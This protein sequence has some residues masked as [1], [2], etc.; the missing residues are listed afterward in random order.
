MR[1]YLKSADLTI[2]NFENPAPNQPRFHAGGTVFSADPKHIKALRDAGI[3]WVSIANNH[4]GDAG[5]QGIVQT[6]ANLKKNGIKAAGAGK[7]ITAARAPRSSMSGT[8]RS[9]CSATTPSPATTRRTVTRRAAC[10]CRSRFD[11]VEGDG[12]LPIGPVSGR[13]RLVI[14]RILRLAPHVTDER[15]RR[16]MLAARRIAKVD[17]GAKRM[18]RDDAS[19]K[20]G[21]DASD[22][23]RRG[24]EARHADSD[25]KTGSPSNRNGRVAP[26]NRCNGQKI[27]QRISAAQQHGSN[28]SYRFRRSMR[29]PASP[30]GFQN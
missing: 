29:S 27:N 22:E 14:E 20:I 12:A 26:V 1:D 3:D 10:R 30:G 17:L 13:R 8:S 7:D 18:V 19:E 16:L 28:L 24:A 4:I 11:P 9:P 15:K 5:R 6:V 21:R 23:S 25:V 2:A